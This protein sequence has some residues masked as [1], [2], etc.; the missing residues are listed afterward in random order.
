MFSE[1]VKE[2][3]EKHKTHFK[4]KWFISYLES[5]K[6]IP[7]LDINN[8]AENLLF[9]QPLLSTYSYKRKLACLYYA[10]Q[11]F[12]QQK[13]ETFLFFNFIVTTVA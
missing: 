10:L 7:Q 12:W 2:N 13:A 1:T 3:R 4:A 9:L 5:F 8:N 11:V 6:K